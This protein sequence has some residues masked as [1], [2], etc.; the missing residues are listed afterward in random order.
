[1][2][3]VQDAPYVYI[4]DVCGTLVRD[5]TTLGLLQH[6]FA[7]GSFP[8]SFLIRALAA[9]RSP[10]RL[11]F[12]VLEK[13]TRHQVLKH[14]ALRM[15][16]GESAA[17]LE[18]SAA[19]YADRLLAE[20]RIRAVWEVLGKKTGASRV[21][22]ASSSLEPIVRQLAAKMNVEYVASSLQETN[23][24]LTGRYQR[25]LTGVKQDA[26]ARKYNL[27]LN[28]SRVLMI[29]DNLSDRP[30]LEAAAAAFVVLHRRA[31]RRRWSG[32]KATFLEIE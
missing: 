27:N 6:H 28:D 4:I 1:M 10:I 13:F 21:I 23:G 22:L 12:A 16:T 31:H 5:D 15:L 17:A 20:R 29:T 8:K 25:D 2:I 7:K 32:M 9:R 3:P 26:L 19:E 11:G 30:M 24:V 14:L 18:R